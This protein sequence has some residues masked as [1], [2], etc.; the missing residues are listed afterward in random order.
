VNRKLYVVDNF[1]KDSGAVRSLALNVHYQ[2]VTKLNYPG[3]QSIHAY[4]SKGIKEK[5]EAIL[6]SEIVI[7]EERLTFGKFRV[8]TDDDRSW[9]KVHVDGIADWSGV[10]YLNNDDQRQG[11]TAFYKH[12]ETG[13]VGPPS[14][15]QIC[16]LGFK[17]YDEFEEQIIGKDTLDVEKWE[18]VMFVGMR[19][20]RLVLFKGNELF[21]AHTHAFGRDIQDGRLTQNFFFNEKTS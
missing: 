12:R 13:L 1:Y 20:G 17:N 16:K 11:G 3:E 8:M 7:D 5:F 10:I 19:F 2:D 18:Q 6:G 14:K 15:E 4:V 9:L 21:H